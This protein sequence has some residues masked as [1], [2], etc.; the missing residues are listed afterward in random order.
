[1]SFNIFCTIVDRTC[2]FWYNNIEVDIM[3]TRAEIL[4]TRILKL[5]ELRDGFAR[6]GQR[7]RILLKNKDKL[8]VATINFYNEMSAQGEALASNYQEQI[9]RLVAK[10][11]QIE[12]ENQR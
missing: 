10:L 12:D 11:Q 5:E 3:E 2:A 7:Y 1:M 9:N 4:R 8:D 6:A